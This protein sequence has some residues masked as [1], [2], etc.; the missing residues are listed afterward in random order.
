M[1]RYNP[2]NI[3]STD[4]SACALTFLIWQR[5]QDPNRQA[6]AAGPHETL[7]DAH[8]LDPLAPLELETDSFGWMTDR[9]VEIARRHSGGRL[10]STLEGGY[11]L[12]ALAESVALHVTRLLEA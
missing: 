11:H 12:D 6:H 7:F 3:K 1:L 5:G 4:L 2:C 10:V 8:K 9:L